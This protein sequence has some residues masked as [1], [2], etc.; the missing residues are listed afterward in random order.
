[1]II[2]IN[3]SLTLTVEIEDVKDIDSRNGNI[4]VLQEPNTLLVVTSSGENVREVATLRF[5]PQS[6]KVSPDGEKVAFYHSFTTGV[7]WLKGSPSQ[8]L[9]KEGDEE[10]FFHPIHPIEKFAWHESS[11][12]GMV[13]LENGVFRVNEL[14]TR[15]S[16]NSWNWD[17]DNISWFDYSPKEESLWVLNKKGELFN[18]PEAV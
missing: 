12:Y 8:P 13:L 18:F 7:I 17:I 11:E 6:I 3:S 2:D 9:K 5:G 15:G 4:F 10:I 16:R 14:D 1:M